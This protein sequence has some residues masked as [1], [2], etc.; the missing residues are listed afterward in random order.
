[1]ASLT[2]PAAQAG[3]GERAS[4]DGVERP[5]S[6]SADDA[7]SEQISRRDAAVLAGCS[8]DTIKRDIRDHGLPTTSGPGGCVLVAIADLLRIGRVKPSNLAVSGHGGQ[9]AQVRRA[10]QESAQL[11]AENGRLTG[12]AEM[13]DKLIDILLEQV[14]VKDKNIAEMQKSLERAMSLASSNRAVSV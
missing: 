13:K 7:K 11:N 14:K 3:Q 12:A 9:S 1:M 8:E 5:T 4:S 6:S 10:E 2:E